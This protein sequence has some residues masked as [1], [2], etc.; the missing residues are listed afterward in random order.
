MELVL[1][2]HGTTAG[3]QTHRHQPEHGRLT[4]EGR[5]EAAA[6]VGF[7]AALQPTHFISS[8][9][10]RALETAAIISHDM[11]MIPSTS[12]LFAELHRPRYMYGQF[13]RSLETA[14]YLAGWFVGL[15]GTSVA[16]DIDDKGESC[17]VFQSRVARARQVVEA[18]PSDSR[19]V[20]V[21]HAV[22]IAFL[23]QHLTTGHRVH[24]WQIP[25]LL[26]HIFTIKNGSATTLRY[27]ETTGRWRLAAYWE[28]SEVI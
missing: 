2:R 25:G 18:Y 24:F 27:D 21:S 5:A 11:D 16:E 3:N 22:F 13:H 8:T 20:V 1:I 28:G 10:V 9:H 14:R 23:I 12:V 4:K 6:L 19:V 15:I 7:V 17:R 26:T